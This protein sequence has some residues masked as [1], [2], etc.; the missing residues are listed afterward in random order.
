MIRGDTQTDLYYIPIVPSFCVDC[1]KNKYNCV[2]FW[3]WSLLII[4][5]IIAA[6]VRPRPWI[7]WG[8]D[9]DD[10]NEWCRFISIS[11]TVF[12]IDITSNY[13]NLFIKIVTTQR[14]NEITFVSSSSTLLHVS[15]FHEATIR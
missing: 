8:S 11:I 5:I 15:P 9:T 14:F 4:I 6:A 13:L 10:N 3:Q 7:L 12:S 2:S 1:I